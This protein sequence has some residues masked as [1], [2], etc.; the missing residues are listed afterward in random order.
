MKVKKAKVFK[1]ELDADFRIDPYTD[2]D[3]D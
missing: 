2:P 1:A 3:P